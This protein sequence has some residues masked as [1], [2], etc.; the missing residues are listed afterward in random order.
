MNTNLFIRN[1]CG[2]RLFFG[3]LS[4]LVAPSYRSQMMGSAIRARAVSLTKNA[5]ITSPRMMLFTSITATGLLMPL[6]KS[7]IIRN[8]AY[9]GVHDVKYP[10]V[11]Y[12]AGVTSKEVRRGRL[13]GK[14]DYRQ[15]CL[16]SI[17]GVALGIV[18]GKISHALVF[19][20]GLGLLALQWLQSRGIV[21]KGTT[22]GLS[23]YLISTGREKIDLNT[24][25]WEKPSFK[26]SFLLTFVLA[27]LNV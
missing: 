8:D 11:G 13:N 5:G 15:L 27:A 4:R 6:F 7:P 2:T 24:L 17:A 23:R 18:V 26:I 9:M 19:I 10:Q 12:G 16:G 21:D 25:F 20:T 22:R 1:P 3:N 14:L